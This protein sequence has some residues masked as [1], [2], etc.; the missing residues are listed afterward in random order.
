MELYTQS[1][2]YLS[3]V[4]VSTFTAHVKRKK[5][6]HLRQQRSPQPQEHTHTYTH[7]KRSAKAKPT[8]TIH[9]VQRT[10]L[11]RGDA[12][13]ALAQGASLQHQ[14]H[15]RHRSHP[16]A[17]KSTARASAPTSTLEKM[18]PSK[19]E[20]AADKPESVAAAAAP[21]K[22]ANGVILGP[23][24]KPYVPPPPSPSAY[25]AP[26]MRA[27]HTNTRL[28]R[29]A[30]AVRATTC[31]LCSRWAEPWGRSARCHATARRTQQRSGA[32]RGRCCTR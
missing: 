11:R 22:L 6:T 7:T 12:T 10:S 14:K 25:D 13:R 9:D 4:G 20:P 18:A 19:E 5:N 1:R 26:R 27:A 21:R 23:D 24:G 2:A 32:A 17:L 31:R 28:T 16:R 29:H 8:L 30:A 3:C 15:R